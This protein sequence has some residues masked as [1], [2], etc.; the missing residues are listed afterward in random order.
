MSFE[1][2]SC[3]IYCMF[4]TAT[5]INCK[6]RHMSDIMLVCNQ[7]RKVR[8]T[9]T[10]TDA[11]WADFIVNENSASASVEL[12]IRGHKEWFPTKVFQSEH[13]FSLRFRVNNDKA[14]FV[15]PCGRLPFPPVFGCI[16]EI[17]K[18][19]L[20]MEH[21]QGYGSICSL[22]EDQRGWIKEGD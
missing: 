2:N 15:R 9:V 18:C 10:P 13:C 4:V 6:A 12:S 11:V 3:N 16:S 14:R 22:G 20:S 17:R 1:S 19:L 8:R 7:F 5:R 21:E